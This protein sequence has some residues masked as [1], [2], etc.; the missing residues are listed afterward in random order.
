[1]KTKKSYSLNKKFLQNICIFNEVAEAWLQSE[2]LS[3]AAP[4]TNFF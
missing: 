1:M 2:T 3:S 4:I